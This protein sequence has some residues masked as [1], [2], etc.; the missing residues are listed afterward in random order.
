MSLLS[1]IIEI[2]S[3]WLIKI[4]AEERLIMA[5]QLNSFIMMDGNAKEA[6]QFYEKALGAK[7]LFKQTIGEGPENPDSP[8]S[9]EDKARIAHSILKIGATDIFVSDLMPGQPL[10]RGNQ[11]SICI[12]TDDVKES[13]QLYDA[14][15]EGGQVDIPL[16]KAYFS[17]AYGVVTDKFGVSFQIFTK[18][19]S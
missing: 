9:A 4:N 12:T 1:A 19:Q 16:N 14:L 2:K 11:V 13:Q 10:T 8:L 3:S 5:M 6:I 15:Q 17:P 7:V 18:R